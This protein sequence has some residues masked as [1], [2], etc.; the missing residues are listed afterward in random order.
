MYGISESTQRYSSNWAPRPST[1]YESDT[2][3][4]SLRLLLLESKKDHVSPPQSALHYTRFRSEY[5]NN[6]IFY[7]SH[8]SFPFWEQ[9]SFQGE[10]VNWKSNMN[11]KKYV[12]ICRQDRQVGRNIRT[13]RPCFTPFF[14]LYRPLPNTLLDLRFLIF[15]LTPFGWLAV[16]R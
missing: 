14:V 16:L 7:G 8:I 9:Y 13:S 15:G 5:Q 10:K 3:R 6:P 12:Q 4:V 1:A 11:W 2:S